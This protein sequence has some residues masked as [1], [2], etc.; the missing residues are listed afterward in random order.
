LIPCR[1]LLA[2][3]ELKL[4]APSQRRRRHPD[5]PRQP[6]R[7]NTPFGRGTGS[8]TSNRAAA[9]IGG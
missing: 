2:N 7:Q 3:R 1:K 8:H 9:P 5:A 6:E 4:A